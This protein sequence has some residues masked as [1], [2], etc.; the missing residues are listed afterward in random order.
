MRV[1]HVVW[2]IASQRDARNNLFIFSLSTHGIGK[3][4]HV[5]AFAQ[6]GHPHFFEDSGV[7]L[8]LIQHVF[9]T[10]HLTRC[11]II[12]DACRHYPFASVYDGLPAPAEE[13]WN[14][15]SV[16]DLKSAMVDFGAQEGFAIMYACDQGEHS[17]EYPKYGGSILTRHLVLGLG[18]NAPQA[19]DT[20]DGIITIETLDVYLRLKIYNEQQNQHYDLRAAGRKILDY[21]WFLD[22][23]NG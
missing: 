13:G 14:K 11:W 8:S 3:G 18:N 6:D 19:T 4:K 5:Y 22:V 10:N 16:S 1:L 20:G 7:S 12:W 15:K 17:F 23:C 9:V 2:K 21:P